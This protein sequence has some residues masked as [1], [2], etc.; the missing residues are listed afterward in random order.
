MGQ[1]GSSKSL[2]CTHK[3]Q[4]I[5]PKPQLIKPQSSQKVTPNVQK[6]HETRQKDAHNAAIIK[7]I[8]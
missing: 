1:K 4:P 2:S 8:L 3:P 6:A 7:E 5:I